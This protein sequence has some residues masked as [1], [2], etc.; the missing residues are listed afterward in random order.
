MLMALLSLTLRYAPE[1]VRKNR[2]FIVLL[3]PETIPFFQVIL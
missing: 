2:L 1:L 3:Q